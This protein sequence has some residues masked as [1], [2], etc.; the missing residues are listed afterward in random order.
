MDED[1][2]RLIAELG[3]IREYFEAK[4]D[5]AVGPGKIVLAHWAEVARGS[6][7]LLTVEEQ[8]PK[9]LT[10]DEVRKLKP[11]T[12]VWEENCPEDELPMAPVEFEGSGAYTFPD[13]M[14]VDVIR[15]TAGME[16]VD[17]YGSRFRLWT[18]KPTEDQRKAVAWDG[19]EKA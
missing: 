11:G 10:L 18:A 15:F 9:L 8:E 7:E 2:K 17:E 16:Y 13:G 6:G 19:K 12:L 5:M 3:H 1:R 4:A 14:R